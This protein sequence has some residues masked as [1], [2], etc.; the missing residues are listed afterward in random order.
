MKKM[1]FKS[2]VQDQLCLIKGN[3]IPLNIQI[4]YHQTKDPFPFWY[5][6]LHHHQS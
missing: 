4:L 2:P 5:Y 3:N 6:V 1:L